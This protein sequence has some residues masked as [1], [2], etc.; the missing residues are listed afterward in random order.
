MNEFDLFIVKLQKADVR[1]IVD[2]TQDEDCVYSDT[3][4]EATYE[5]L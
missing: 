1:I 5:W 4:P 2:E 3:K